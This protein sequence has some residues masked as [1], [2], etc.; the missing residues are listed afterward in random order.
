[1]FLPFADSD[2]TFDDIS[3][4]E[5]FFTHG[6]PDFSN[7]DA[8][9]EVS[10]GPTKKASTAQSL[11]NIMVTNHRSIFPKF[12]NL[13]DELIECEM[14]VGIHS[15]IWEDKEKPEHKNKIEEALELHGIIYISNPR[16]KR[17]GGGAAITLCDPRG[18]F[19]LS[20]LPIH[21]PPDL[22]VC[23]G[24]VKPRSP[25]P[26]KE[27]VICS[28][29]CPPYSK[30]KSKLVEHISVNYFMMKSS[31]PN[32]AFVCGGDKNDLNIKHLLDI[33]PNFRQ[34]VTKP[35][36][37]KSILEVIVTDIGHYYNEPVIRP[38]LLPDIPGHGVPSDHKIV[39]A[40]PNKDSSMPPKRSTIVKSSRPL[41]T[42]AKQNIAKW[43]QSETWSSLL[44]C[45]DCSSMVEAFTS[46]VQ[47]KIDENCPLKTLKLNCFDKEFTSPA[48]KKLK[49]KKSR[50][51]TKNGNSS[52]YKTLKKL[53]KK[54]IKEEGQKFISK[55]I[56]LAGEKGNKWIR[57]TAALLARPGD[58]PRNTFDL[59]EHVERGLSELESAEEIANFFSKISQEYDPL[60]L[61]TLPE[62]VQSKLAVDPC[63]HPTYL[64]HEIYLELLGTKKTCSVPGDIPIDILDEFLP[65]FS[66]PIT[67]IINKSFS[68]HQ[69]PSS[70]RKEFGIPINKIPIP[71][72]E[73]DLR[74]IGLTPYLSKRMEKLL[75]KWI[76]KYIS[77]HIGLD[78]L[79]GLPGCSIVHYIIRMVDFILS[80]LDNSSKCPSAVIAA[81]VD[82]SKAFNRMSHNKIITILS[83]LNIPTCAL[84]LIISYLTD[85]TLVIRY[86]GAVSS[87]RSMPGGG[88]QGTL[89][90]V[91]LFIL[92]VNHAGDPCPVPA[93]LAAGVAGPEPPPD[94]TTYKPCHATGTTENTKFVDDLTLLEVV[95][96]KGN[97]VPQDTFIGP[98]NYHERHGLKFP[99]ESIIIQHK[100]EDLLKFTEE[101]KMKINLKKTKIIPFNFS[102]SMDFIPELHFPGGE[103]LEVI[104][105][106][107]LVG[108]IVDSSLSW[109]P[110]VDYTVKNASKKLWLLIRFKNIGATQD[111]L[112]TLYQLKIRCLAEFAAPAFHSS[113]TQ[114]QSN[115]LEM[116]QK[117]AFAIILGSNYRSYRNALEKL[118]Q[119]TL[120]SR[121]LQLCKNF[122]VKCTIHPR[123]SDLFT[124][125]PRYSNS[126]NKKKFI[127]PKCCTSRYYK[128]AVPFLTRLLNKI[129]K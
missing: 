112:L 6:I 87:E 79:G 44:D 51:Y 89:L 119:E 19:S 111:Q 25:G 45:S 3:I 74:S 114:Q 35:S 102:K 17:R 29:Y 113:L 97:L 41:T 57:S 128:S 104:Y 60:C 105:Q 68:T 18:L 23:W 81:T 106:T 118:S 54:T 13:V 11:P 77:P 78:Q 27:I 8:S 46:L 47:T 34:I 42:E 73:D 48:I 126:R 38:A 86:H 26:I 63:D 98:P 28:F 56:E 96:L 20:K 85:R 100:L 43:I 36:H 108:V 83:D 117:K 49:R 9:V 37:G 21:V 14:H 103:S 95:K 82:F 129:E 99:P 59:P 107:K 75:I 1:M 109:G 94:V 127:E 55:Q 61:D 124:L 65:E 15:E 70:F 80:N 125:N 10:A 4:G 24:L 92:Q 84:R 2:I 115:E 69:W 58:S 30:K 123:H 50:E 88:P 110:H 93:T 39:H 33:S 121:R 16:P 76:W 122:A 53:L 101:N 72:T 40:V 22:E 12:Q 31:Y 71:E 66:T 91:L 52:L 7:L 64:E 5:S 90:I 62:R 120:H 67:A 32:C 116:L